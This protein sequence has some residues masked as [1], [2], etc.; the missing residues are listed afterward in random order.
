M[1]M[2]ISKLVSQLLVKVLLPMIVFLL[3]SSIPAITGDILVSTRLSAPIIRS[4]IP[5]YAYSPP[6]LLNSLVEFQVCHYDARFTLSI[7]LSGCF[8]SVSFLSPGRTWYPDLSSCC[9]SH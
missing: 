1:R 4:E 8:I 7:L 9:L 3:W 2:Q 5:W 6:P